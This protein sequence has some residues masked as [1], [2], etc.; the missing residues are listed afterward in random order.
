MVKLTCS[1]N[2]LN[3]NAGRIQLLGKLMDS[4]VRV[5]VGFRVNVCFGAWK[6]NCR[7]VRGL[8]LRF[9]MHTV[10]KVPDSPY[11]NKG[12][13]SERITKQSAEGRHRWPK[14]L[15]RKKTLNH[16]LFFFPVFCLNKNENCVAIIIISLTDMI[17]IYIFFF[18]KDLKWQK[19]DFMVV[20][21][22]E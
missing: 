1:N 4:P 14:G 2:S 19:L 3:L 5:L 10:H 20:S 6:F 17:Y 21:H 16:H 8:L 22:P 7:R 11:N 18:T 9:N 13:D 12:D 15:P